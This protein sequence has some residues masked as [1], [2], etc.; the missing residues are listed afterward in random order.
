MLRNRDKA[1]APSV[2]WRDLALGKKYD[3]KTIGI[4]ALGLI[5]IRRRAGPSGRVSC[6]MRPRSVP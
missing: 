2:D 1:G 6:S 3:R 5:T 4:G